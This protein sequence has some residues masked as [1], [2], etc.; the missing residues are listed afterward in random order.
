MSSLI[1]KYQPKTFEDI[2]GQDYIITFFKLL[3]KNPDNYPKNIILNG[4]WGTGKTSTARIF[5]DELKKITPTHLYEYDVS[6]FN[7][8]I[9][10]EIKSKIDNQF[11]FSKDYRV[12]IFDEIQSASQSSQSLFLKTLEN[13]IIGNNN[14]KIF[15]LF[16]TTD[17]SKLIDPIISRCIEL[18]FLYISYENIKN[19]LKNI[20][21]KE[22]IFINDKEL[23]CIAKYS[24]GH[25]RDAIIML[26]RYS[27][28]QG[29]FKDIIIDTKH[30]INEYLY[31]KT[32]NI[33]KITVYPVN[34]L[35]RDLKE[36]VTDF[37]DSHIDIDY[38]LTLQY[39]ELFLKFKNYIFSIED[40]INVLKI[41]KKFLLSKVK[42]Y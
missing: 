30:L 9:I 4:S 32:D 40:F 41:I 38:L 23:G 12:L 10:K 26:N 21:E 8:D 5:A 39:L 13:N 29:E 37:V 25:L 35:L 19:K 22:N 11:S 2:V 7:K 34:I 28:L 27:I 14:R 31:N 1:D 20:S 24:N 16:L 42:S 6:I 33:D 15:F 17:S 18:N 3:L 36:L